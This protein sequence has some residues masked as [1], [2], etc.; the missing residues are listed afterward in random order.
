V[1]K[2]AIIKLRRRIALR[3]SNRQSSRNNSFDIAGFGYVS[4]NSEFAAHAQAN[5]KDRKFEQAEKQ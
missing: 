1:N 3:C 5:D 4:L 2:I